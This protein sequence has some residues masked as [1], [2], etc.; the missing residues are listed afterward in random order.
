VIVVVAPAVYDL[1]TLGTKWL[2]KGGGSFERE[3]K[4]VDDTTSL[5]PSLST[6]VFGE[7]HSIFDNLVRAITAETSHL[8]F[9]AT[10]TSFGPG[11]VR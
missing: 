11:K 4:F 1:R 8:P 6:L 7:K 5:K 2:G 10:A 3:T 9:V